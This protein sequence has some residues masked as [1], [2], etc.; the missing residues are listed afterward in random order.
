VLLAYQI[1]CDFSGYSDIVIGA[2]QVMGIKLTKNFMRQYSSKSITEFWQRWHISLSTWIRDYLYIPLAR[3]V[4]EITDRKRP[5]IIQ[6]TVSVIVM[7]IVG[8]WHGANW[9]FIVWGA[10]HG[11]YLG[12]EALFRPRVNQTS[13]LQWRQFLGNSLK[14][15]FTFSLLCFAWIFFRASTMSDAVYIVTHLFSGLSNPLSGIK[16]LFLILPPLDWILIGLAVVVNEVVQFLQ[17]K[18]G[19]IRHRLSLQ[20]VVVRWALYY[21]LILLILL[22]GRF[23]NSQFLYFQF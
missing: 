22:F 18:G 3:K 19:S 2:A 15:G 1:Y 21:A 11:V 4:M 16:T 12:V 7:G 8:L 6:F 17:G 9:T 13:N 23:H 14:I 20:P 10:L 5:R